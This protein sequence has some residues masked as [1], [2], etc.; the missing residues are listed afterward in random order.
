[1]GG[2]SDSDKPRRYI[3]YQLSKT[4][5]SPKSI[6]VQEDALLD[7]AR[8]DLGANIE[9]MREMQPCVR[10]ALDLIEQEERDPRRRS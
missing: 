8:R 5:E 2:V 3:G 1:V 7:W 10:E 4:P 6:K 9:A